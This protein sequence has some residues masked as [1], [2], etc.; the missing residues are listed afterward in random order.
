MSTRHA[1]SVQSCQ[2]GMTE[3]VNNSIMKSYSLRE[4]VEGDIVINA[5]KC[6]GKVKKD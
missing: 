6:R 5:F 1:V 2:K 4:T 3:T